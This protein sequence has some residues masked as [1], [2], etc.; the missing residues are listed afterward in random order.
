MGCVDVFPCAHL[1]RSETQSWMLAP[2]GPTQAPSFLRGGSAIVWARAFSASDERRC[3]CDTLK[4]VLEV[5]AWRA[6]L[7]PAALLTAKSS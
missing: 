7:H 1:R 6:A 5:R 3:D 2:D 4:S